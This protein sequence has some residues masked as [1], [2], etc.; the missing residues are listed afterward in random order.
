MNNDTIEQIKHINFLKRAFSLKMMMKNISIM[1]LLNYLQN[2][3][4]PKKSLLTNLKYKQNVD[5]LKKIYS[6][7]YF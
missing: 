5:D 4:Y 7:V 3:S 1:F 2:Y 6:M